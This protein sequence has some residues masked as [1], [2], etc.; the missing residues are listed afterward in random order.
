MFEVMRQLHEDHERVARL[1][2]LMDEQISAIQAAA[3]ADFELMLDA[4]HYILH[5]ADEFHHPREDAM[6][7]RLKMSGADIEKTLVDLLREHKALAEKGDR[8]HRI[9]ETVVDGSLVPREQIGELGLDY[10]DFLR[11]HMHKEETEAFPVAERELTHG[12][13]EAIGEE[14]EHQADPLFGAVVAKEYEALYRILTR[15]A[16]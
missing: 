15:S 2:D 10:V 12:D 1:L 4:M 8:F 13:W 6:F 9:L 11:S 14:L 5:Y 3:R 7:E 16:S